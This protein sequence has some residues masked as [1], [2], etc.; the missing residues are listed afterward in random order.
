MKKH[1]ILLVKVL[2]FIMLLA[3]ILVYFKDFGVHLFGGG[4]IASTMMIFSPKLF[5]TT[6]LFVVALLLFVYFRHNRLFLVF[7]F[8][9]F[10]F[11]FI[12]GRTVGV[13]WTGKVVYGWF[14][15]PTGQFEIADLNSDSM[16]EFKLESTS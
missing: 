11:W 12:S 16:Q 6:G 1:I 4:S 7:F 10:S 15:F 13:H 2:V 8:L 5:V 14:Y 3:T 9:F